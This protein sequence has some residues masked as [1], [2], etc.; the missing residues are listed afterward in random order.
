MF[1]INNVDSKCLLNY[2]LYKGKTMR[3]VHKKKYFSSVA[4]AT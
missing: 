1:E 4:I 2:T 3:S